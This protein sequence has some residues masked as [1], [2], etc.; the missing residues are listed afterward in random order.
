MLPDSDI[1]TSETN[2]S[3]KQ[4]AESRVLTKLNVIYVL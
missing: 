1:Q 4:M 2:P 3:K